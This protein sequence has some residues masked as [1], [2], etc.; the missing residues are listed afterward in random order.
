M[1]LDGKTSSENHQRFVKRVSAA[2]VVY[3]L[4]NDEGVAN[5]ESNDYED[6]M[7]LPFW[8]DPAYA[9]RAERA[10]TESFE[11]KVI[12][13]FDFLYR[14]L[15]GMTGDGVLAGTNWNG[16]LCGREIDP[17]VLR[18]EIEESMG[19]DLCEQY[20]ERCRKAMREE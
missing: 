17:Y 1:L 4:V 3:Y 16:Q 2:E 14:W 19:P 20:D 12:P 10:F 6:V 5:S 18:T 11:V 8:S 15:P 13:L 7:V 9:R